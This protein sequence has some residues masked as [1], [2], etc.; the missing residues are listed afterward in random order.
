MKDNEIKKIKN[1]YIKFLV[2][3]VMF[4]FFHGIHTCTQTQVCIY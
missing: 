1:R 3:C 2:E 4:S